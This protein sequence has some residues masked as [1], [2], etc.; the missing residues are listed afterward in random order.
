MTTSFQLKS[1]SGNYNRK[2]MSIDMLVIFL[3]YIVLQ[4][5]LNHKGTGYYYYLNKEIISV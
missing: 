2:E 3:D 5:F 1:T 4:S